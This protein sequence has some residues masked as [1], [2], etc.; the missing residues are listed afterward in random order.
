LK[1]DTKAEL[2]ELENPFGY[3]HERT[4]QL[5]V[6]GV[7]KVVWIFT[8]TKKV[9]VAEPKKNWQISPW[10][11]EIQILDSVFVTLQKLIDQA[12]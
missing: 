10:E 9:M 3:Y 4:D 7:E 12:S 1:I 2:S 5:L 6:F 8:D 11:T